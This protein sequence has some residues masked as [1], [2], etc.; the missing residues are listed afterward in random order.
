MKKEIKSFTFYRMEIE[1]VSERYISPCFV[2]GLHAYDGEINLK[3]EKNMISNEFTVKLC[4]EYE[5]KNGEKVVK[6]ELLVALRG[7]L[8]FFKF[9]INPG[10]DDMKPGVVFGRSFLRLTKRIF[11]FRNIIL[12]IYPDLITFNDDSDDDLDALLASIDVSDLPLLDITN[13][14]PFMCSMGKSIGNKKQ[15]SRTLPHY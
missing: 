15:P 6:K 3:Y 8:Y 4:L 2:D 10:E 12:T 13:I 14:P 5:E 7:E 9:I 11:D 1:E